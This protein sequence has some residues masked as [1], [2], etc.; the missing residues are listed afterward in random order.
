MKSTL[1][2]VLESLTSTDR[3]LFP[4]Q[5]DDFFVASSETI[6]ESL[7]SEFHAGLKYP[8][9]TSGFILKDACKL[10]GIN[11]SVYVF[12]AMSMSETNGPIRYPAVIP[13]WRNQ[14]NIHDLDTAE[15]CVLFEKTSD[16]FLGVVYPSKEEVTLTLQDIQRLINEYNL[17][18]RRMI[19]KHI[20]DN[21]QKHDRTY[22][23]ECLNTT[24][25][26]TLICLHA[27]ALEN[28]E[29]EDEYARLISSMLSSER[30][31]ELWRAHPFFTE[32]LSIHHEGLPL[33]ILNSEV[34]EEQAP[35]EVHEMSPVERA[36]QYV[37]FEKRDIYVIIIYAILIGLVSL[38]TPL[39]INALV[40]TISAGVFTMPLIVLS[41][42]IFTGILVAGGVGIA[43]LYVVELLQ[44]RI[45][46]NT[47][48]EI[49]YKFPHAKQELFSATY[50]PELLN[51][52][53]DI[54]TLQKGIRK[55]LIDGLSAVVIGTAGL[56]LLVFIS[57]ELLA[58]GVLLLVF[59]L[60]LVYVLGKNGLKT[61]M[62]E[63]KKKYDVAGFLE[64]M[65]R[66]VGSFKLIGSNE[67][68]FKRIDTLAS[69]YI[70]YR[71][72]H[73]KI[74]LRQHLGFTF[75]RAAVNTGVLAVG[76]WLVF[77]RQITLGQLVATEIVIVTLIN[78]LEKLTNQLEVIY[79]TLTAFDKV[80]LVT[81]IPLERRG[82]EKLIDSEKGISV[83]CEHVSFAYDKRP[84]LKDIHFS[85]DAGSHV[86][87]V[88]KSGAGKSTLS[89]LFLGVME[90]SMGTILIDD[91]DVRRL[92]LASIRKNIG[93]VFPHDEIF[94][95][96]VWDNI[97]LGREW[98]TG[99]DVMKAIRLTRL[100]EEFLRFPK[101]L[102][103]KVLSHG[104]NLSTGQIRRLMIA[105]AIVHKPRL[106]ILDE[107][108]TGIEEHMKLAIIK[109]LYS[110]E[111]QWTVIS[112][113][114]DPEVLMCSDYVYVLDNG[115]IAEEG[116]PEGLSSQKDSVLSSMFPELT[117]HIQAQKM[118]HNSAGKSNRGL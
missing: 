88:G 99:R 26:S 75:I 68:I 29:T 3:E 77:E 8:Y 58:L 107:A 90:T 64:D 55:L 65:A 39:T 101:G 97:T 86:A 74:L 85:V 20:N 17:I 95:G 23:V 114:H 63:S 13:F 60:L 79:D 117:I 59:S 91:V 92:D 80:S 24:D 12:D 111:Y 4:K 45:F 5:V 9:W 78:S 104:R 61:S 48:F 110:S 35:K 53:F 56:L 30:E 103:T 70:K 82:G 15:L 112:I 93:L 38:V 14:E 28:T 16:A 66:S 49:G 108:F 87:L 37:K 115:I 67:Y 89:Q 100:D 84:L 33:L 11:S 47:A 21:T 81:D 57:P 73:F 50:A 18:L 7:V 1:I 98:V 41:A 34:H 6:A 2:S 46:V 43:Q 19:E 54:V 102:H 69:D 113:T 51:R 52:F 27:I 116:T 105:R 72:Q 25:T 31:Q 40:T 94:D 76:G 36:L 42:I 22:S 109:D 96:T 83:H 44:Q 10:M 62:A 32:W 118:S 71:N 106:L